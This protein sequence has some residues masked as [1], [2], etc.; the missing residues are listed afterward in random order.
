MDR[1]E[2]LS[3]GLVGGV[4]TMLSSDL[5]YGS[6]QALNEPLDYIMGGKNI[7]TDGGRIGVTNGSAKISPSA[8]VDIKNFGSITCALRVT[9][10]WVGATDKPYQ[11]NDTSLYEVFNSVSSSSSNRSWAGSFA[12]AYNN[13]PE[14]VV[15]SGERVAVIGWATSVADHGYLHAG[16]LR[17]QI[18]ILGRAGFQGA[19]SAPSAVIEEAIGVRGTIVNDSEGATIKNAIAG[20]FVSSATDGPVEDNVAVFA[21]ATNGSESN[22]SFMGVGGVLY[23]ADQIQAG[24]TETQSGACVAARSSGNSYEFG[25]PD[26]NGYSSNLGATQSRGV[27]F[28]AFCAEADEVGDTF[29]TRGK[30]GAVISSDLAGSIVFSRVVNANASGQKLDESA[31]INPDGHLVLSNSLVIRKKIPASSADPGVVGEVCWGEDYV[32]VCVAP[33]RWRRSKLADW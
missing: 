6:S 11:N 2:L 26:A 28:L 20:Q 17:R 23:N 27:P 21:S 29:T 14:G 33:N 12:N 4:T 16:T 31:R 22:Y 32:Y 1:R 15:D 7:V 9:S 24:S 30:L 3:A 13:I 18:G 25:H 5:A 10:Y 19:G 8:L